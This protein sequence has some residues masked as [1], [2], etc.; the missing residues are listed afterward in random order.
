MGSVSGAVVCQTMVTGLSSMVRGAKPICRADYGGWFEFDDARS[1]AD[2]FQAQLSVARSESDLFEE[3]WF[4][5]RGAA[6]FVDVMLFYERTYAGV[7]GTMG[8]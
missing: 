6:W 5:R 1:E 7:G 3:E 8:N 2:L 4:A